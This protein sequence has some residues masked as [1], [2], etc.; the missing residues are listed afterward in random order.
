MR[1]VLNLPLFPLQ[2]ADR[3]PEK[4]R[5]AIPR[6][7]GVLEPPKPALLSRAR[8]R[9]LWLAIHLSR[10]ALEALQN[11]SPQPSPTSGRGSRPSPPPSP[12]SSRERVRGRCSPAGGRGSGS[13]AVID[14]D[15][16]Q[17]IVLACNE[18]ARAA[19]VRPGQSLNAAIAL[20]PDLRAL[21]REA[22]KE[23][24]RLAQ[25]AAW[26]QQ[27]F[28]PLVSVESEDELLLEVKGSLRLF[29]G[30]RVLMERI[31]TGL[32]E[33]S[34]TAQLALTP[35]P[36]SALWLARAGPSPPPS[37]ASSRERVRGR[38]SPTSGRGSGTL[39]D[40]PE[41]LAR[42][43]APVSLRHLR[44]P[45]ELLAQLLSM[46]LR[47]VGDLIRLPRGGVVRR[48]GQV[49]LDELDRALGRRAD[50]RRGF[51]SPERFDERRM[52]EYEIETAAGLEI[53]CEPL[54]TRLQEFLR[55]RQAAIAVLAVD[56]KHRAHSLTRLRIGLAAPSGDVGHLRGLLAERLAA[57][58]LPAPVVAIRMRSGALLEQALATDSFRDFAP[59]CDADALPRLIERL[60]ARLGHEAVFGVSGVEDHRPEYAWRVI[61]MPSPQPS[62]TSGRGGGASPQPSPASGRGNG[63]E[64]R[65]LWLLAEPLALTPTLSRVLAGEGLRTMLSRKREREWRFELL[66]GP[67]RIETGWWDGREVTRDYF[68]ARDAHGVRLWVYRDRCA[69]QNWYVHGLFG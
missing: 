41:A 22:R 49:W 23:R 19:G 27:Q 37:P 26:C 67:E 39:I 38:C 43:L 36:R 53:A 59:S 18:A 12:A 35:T 55:R 66:C 62:P 14:P 32:S 45:E 69:P 2:P 1:P 25:L 20:A 21:P 11:P 3:E 51:R 13:L 16:R 61:E 4:R 8:P 48:L 40:R 52:L 17:Q 65:P 10:L 44:W 5:K 56:F 31:A 47:T 58:T 54:L 24:E 15:S 42:R 68:V 30:A 9:Q 57:L 60:R 7:A 63:R 6:P 64:K 50:V 46:G 28:T 29:G 33:Q 34:V